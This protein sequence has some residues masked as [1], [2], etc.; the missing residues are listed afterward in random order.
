MNRLKIWLLAAGAWGVVFG[1]VNGF[2]APPV[3]EMGTLAPRNSSYEK[4]L[5]AMASA[6]AKAP[7][8]G[9]ELKIF[10]GGVIGSEAD[11]VREMRGG[12][13]QAALLTTAGLAE[14]ERSVIGLQNLPVTFQD[15]DE[16]EFV[17][18]KIQPELER[19]I[20]AKG[21]KV[22]FWADTGWIY[23]FSKNPIRTPDDLRNEKLFVWEG[24]PGIVRIFQESG[25]N[26]VPLDPSDA[27]LGLKQNIVTVMP[28][29]PF[30]AMTSQIDRAAPYMLDLKWALLMGAAVIENGAWAELPDESKSAL[31]KIG[32]ATGKLV[33]EKGREES[34]LSIR[35]M[36]DRRGLKV[37]PA[38]DTL[39]KTWREEVSKVKSSMRG[40]IVP[41]DIYDRVE[42]ALREYRSR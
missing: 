18:S 7:G 22:L 20:E 34:E 27:I 12:G 41:A 21:F 36:R 5:Q 35:A 10:S 15:Y 24:S 19:R 33:I 8:G 32:A 3:I 11:M 1:G 37:I 4:A 26:P 39:R 16:W 14:I 23:F 25:F 40:D 31:E 13:I 17:R 30:Y 2:A 29:P 28:S 6:W 9:V 42:A 38:D